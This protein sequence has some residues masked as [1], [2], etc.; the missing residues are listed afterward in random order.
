MELARRFGTMVTQDIGLLLFGESRTPV[1]C[2]PVS[3]EDAKFA[4]EL[5]FPSSSSYGS[6]TYPGLPALAFL[7]IS[8][9][10]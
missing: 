4:L 6:Y 10:S 7:D 5:A 2:C 8:F 9:F 3:Q 1:P